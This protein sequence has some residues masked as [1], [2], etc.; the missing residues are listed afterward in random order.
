MFKDGRVVAAL[1]LGSFLVLG[2]VL[3][4]SLLMEADRREHRAAKC[5]AIIASNMDPIIKSTYMQQW[6]WDK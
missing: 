3:V 2:S 4:V 5:R 6:C 1:V